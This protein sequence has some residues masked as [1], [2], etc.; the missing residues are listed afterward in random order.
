[1]LWNFVGGKKNLACNIYHV[2]NIDMLD[3]VDLE[4]FKTLVDVVQEISKELIVNLIMN[5]LRRLSIIKESIYF[6]QFQFLENDR[7]TILHQ[8]Q[9][10]STFEHRSIMQVQ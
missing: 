1:M 5:L 4:V 7:E 10:F 2:I 8:M 9:R 3:H 6:H